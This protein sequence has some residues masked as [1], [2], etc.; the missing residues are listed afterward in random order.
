MAL[1]EKETQPDQSTDGEKRFN[2]RDHIITLLHA[3][4]GYHPVSNHDCF[5]YRKELVTVLES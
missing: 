4:S 1:V 2:D 5:G 3:T